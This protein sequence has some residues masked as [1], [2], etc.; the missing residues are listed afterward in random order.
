MATGSIFPFS[1]NGISNDRI[2]LIPFDPER[3]GD[4]FF[5]L[6]SPY[7]E[8]YSHMPVGPWD[9]ANDF[10][11]EF[12]EGPSNGI[13]SF[14]N[15]ESFTFAIIDKTRAPS[16]EDPEGEL[17]GTMSFIRTS[18]TH[19]CTEVGFVVIL[20]PYQRTHVA[21]NAVGLVLH[22]ALESPERGGMGL[23]RV[24]WRASTSNLASSKLAEKMG[25]ERVG[26]VPW[27]I[28]FVKGK[29]RGKIGNGKELPPD[30]DPDDVWRDTVNYCL[31]WDRWESGVRETVQSVID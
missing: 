24:D 28:R 22:L 11:R 25:F 4:T 15:P 16:P 31:A 12:T 3:H 21:R 30:C 18:P 26:V 14:S 1:I 19:L 5:N 17:A 7:P 20:P 29:L 2:K 23:R 6:S 27:H 10:K 8:I 9:S 13:I